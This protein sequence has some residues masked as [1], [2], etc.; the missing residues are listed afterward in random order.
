M[1]R[2]AFRGLRLGLAVV[3]VYAVFSYL[4]ALL[5]RQ[6]YYQN[7][8]VASVGMMLAMAVDMRAHGVA[9]GFAAAVVVMLAHFGLAW[10]GVVLTGGT[11]S[12]LASELI[13]AILA[14]VV[15]AIPYGVYINSRRRPL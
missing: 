10:L 15:V 3:C 1:N 8:L 14:T 6:S 5:L 9:A 13:S 2:T 4:T 11:T 12:H 7:F